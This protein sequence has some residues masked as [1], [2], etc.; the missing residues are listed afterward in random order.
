[1]V[2]KQPILLSGDEFAR[3]VKQIIRT[4]DKVISADEL[5]VIRAVCR[6]L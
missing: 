3:E 4:M 5:Q 2:N 6:H 1:M